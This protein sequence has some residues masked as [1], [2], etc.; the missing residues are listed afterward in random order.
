MPDPQPDWWVQARDNWEE[1]YGSDRLDLLEAEM[2]AMVPELEKLTGRSFDRA[3]FTRYLERINEQEAIMDEATSV[4]AEAPRL[5]IRISEQIPNVMIPQWHRGSD[6]A[7]SHSRAFLEEVK[8]RVARDE[9]VC[10]NERIR[11]MWIGAGLWFD[12][13]FYTRFEESHGAVFAWSMYLPFAGDGYIRALNDRPMR[14]LAAR[15]SAINEQLHQPPWVNSWMVEQARRF[16]IDVALMLVPEHDRFGG[17]GSFFARNALEAAGVRVIE[18]HSD[19]VDQRDWDGD[20]I[21]ARV[22][23]VLDE[24]AARKSVPAD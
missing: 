16:R 1:F 13:G 21:T 5:P 18:V 17:Y 22:S 2:E 7:L 11:M 24:V 14:S 12:T 3:A 23:E 8:G 19:M 4:V 9:A 6:W 20:A 10:E 15:V